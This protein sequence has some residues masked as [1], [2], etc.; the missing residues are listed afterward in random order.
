MQITLC[1]SF[2]IYIMSYD[3]NMQMNH[4]I[5]ERLCLPPS[6]PITYK[7]FPPPPHPPSH[8]SSQLY[9]QDMHHRDHTLAIVY[10]H[11]RGC[12]RGYCGW[13]GKV[14]WQTNEEK[15]GRKGAETRVLGKCLGGHRD[16][17]TK[18]L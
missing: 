12:W 10:A 16:P 13:V 11:K 6:A 2:S 14:I 17:S 15:G 5:Y 7:E 3:R 4:I 8:L 18:A 9:W 1:K